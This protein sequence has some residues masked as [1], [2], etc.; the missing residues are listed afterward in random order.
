MPWAKAMTFFAIFVRFLRQRR[1]RV[2]IH[3]RGAGAT[4]SFHRNFCVMGGGD[5]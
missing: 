4:L 1:A 2:N 5:A 3:L